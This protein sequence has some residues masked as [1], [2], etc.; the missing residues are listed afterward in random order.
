[1]HG[2]LIRNYWCAEIKLTELQV[3]ESIE[4]QLVVASQ[5]YVSAGRGKCWDQNGG[6]R[7]NIHGQIGRV[8]AA[9]QASGATTQQFYR[10]RAKDPSRCPC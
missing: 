10:T 3:V 6:G 8:N 4:V 5:C 2:G 1:M 9:Q 7:V